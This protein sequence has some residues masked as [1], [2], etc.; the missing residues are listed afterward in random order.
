M[1]CFSF[2]VITEEGI[3]EELTNALFEA[4]CDDSGI[5]CSCGIWSVHFDRDADSLDAAIRSATEQ[6][7]PDGLTS[8]RVT[9][10][11]ADLEPPVQG[12]A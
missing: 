5:G 11:K 7:R 8:E 4:G 12:P 2:E 1:P 3:T 9:I 6:V 10:E